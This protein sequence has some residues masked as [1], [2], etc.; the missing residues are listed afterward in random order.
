MTTSIVR[1]LYFYVAAFI[2]LQLLATGLRMLIATLVERVFWS[3]AIGSL[4]LEVERLSSGVA[5]LV[6]GLVFWGIH[7]SMVQRNQGRVEEQRS[8]LRRLYGYAVLLIAMFGLL[9]ATRT[10]LTALFGGEPAVVSPG[11]IAQ[12]SA[13][14]IVNAVIWIYHW[15][16]LAVD[17]QIVEVAGGAATL[18]RWYLV[19]VLGLSLGMAAYGAVEVLH[20]V[21]QLGLGPAIGGADA[22][23]I[24][25][26][27]LI[28]GLAS[29]LAHHLW[30]RAL[31]HEQTVLRADEARS[32]LRQVYLAL[33]VTV[34]AIAA[35][36]GLVA[37]VAAVLRAL[38]GG[39][40]WSS[41]LREQTQEVAIALIGLAV[42]RFHR[43]LLVEEAD[44]SEL[45]ARR[46]T[47]Q[48]ISSYLTSAIGLGALFF[49]L[50]GVLSTLLRLGLAPAVLGQEWRD[51]LSLYLALALVALPVYALTARANEHAAGTSQVEARTL[52]RRIYLYAALLFG[53][54]ATLVAIVQLVRIATVVVLG[55]DEPNLLAEVARWLGY[56]VIGGVIGAYHLVLVRRI[57]SGRESGAG[58]TVAIVAEDSMC[59]ALTAAFEREL[60]GSTLHTAGREDRAGAEAALR[61]AEVLITTIGTLVGSPVSGLLEG[62]GGLRL[63]LATPAPGYELIGGRGGEEA[64][65]RAAVR[66]VREGRAAARTEAARPAPMTAVAHMP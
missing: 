27:A 8:T 51:Q 25:I 29:W 56:A 63:L 61:D 44:A 64:V 48:R 16:V 24:S 43:L 34:S 45:T 59:A 13:A 30:A 42:W 6:V 18:R 40:A 58:L 17:R 54:I 55:Q 39:V 31:L 15:R 47:A 10:F 57:G 28:V 35:L 3:A 20:R 7:W 46:E 2:G 11:E 62:F 36:G 65:A 1:R 21:L 32:S 52:A 37:L 12:A 23:S 41:V 19:I 38:L 26:S 14:L 49:G 9:F 22:A 33:V 66:R 5:L 4:D 50:G 60:P 53:I